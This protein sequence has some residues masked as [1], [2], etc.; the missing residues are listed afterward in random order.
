MIRDWIIHRVRAFVITERRIP[1]ISIIP[2]YEIRSWALLNVGI[3]I[4]IRVSTGNI[5]VI[6][7]RCGTD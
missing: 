2:T 7:Y 5:Y 6:E 4:A 3:P 1:E